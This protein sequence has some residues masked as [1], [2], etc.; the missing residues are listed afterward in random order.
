LVAIRCVSWSA[1]M[2][3]EYSRN[4]IQGIFEPFFNTKGRKGSGPGTLD[5]SPALVTN[6]VGQFD[7]GVTFAQGRMGPAFSSP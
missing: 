4:A 5:L 2:G 7:S 1:I 6:M 3:L